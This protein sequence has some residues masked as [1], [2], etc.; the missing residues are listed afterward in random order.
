MHCIYTTHQRCSHHAISRNVS[1]FFVSIFFFFLSKLPSWTPSTFYRSPF[2]SDLSI[3]RKIIFDFIFEIPHKCV[4]PQSN[5][6]MLAVIEITTYRS[7]LSNNCV[8]ILFKKHSSN[9][10]IIHLFSLTDFS[11]NNR[12]EPPPPRPAE[13]KTPYSVD[14]PSDKNKE[15]VNMAEV[16][17][18]NCEPLSRYFLRDWKSFNLST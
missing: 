8:K 6:Y 3:V 5:K 15:Q 17:V 2:K 7:Y 1:T 14:E 10:I 11:N 13:P 9:V 4:N 16:F 12:I 18:I